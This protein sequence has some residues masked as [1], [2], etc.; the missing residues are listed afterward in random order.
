MA[1]F[2]GYQ[3]R[4]SR[5]VGTDEE[6]RLEIAR[7]SA[8]RADRNLLRR[9][10]HAIPQA[11]GRSTYSNLTANTRAEASSLRQ[12]ASQAGVDKGLRNASAKKAFE[13][14]GIRR[15][16]A[17]GRDYVTRAGGDTAKHGQ[18]AGQTSSALAGPEKVVET[19][20][21]AAGAA[22]ILTGG[23]AAPVVGISEGV[24]QGLVAGRT[25][26]NGTES[27]LHGH[28]ARTA[29]RAQ[30]QAAHSDEQAFFSKSAELHD[31][32][33]ELAA[34]KGARE[35]LNFIAP[36]ASEVSDL[37]GTLA[38]PVVN[39]AERHLDRREKT[40]KERRGQAIT[41]RSS[42]LADVSAREANTFAV[43]TQRLYRGARQ[44]TLLGS[45]QEHAA[46]VGRQAIDDKYGGHDGRRDF[47]ATQVQRVFRGHRAREENGLER[48][49]S[50]ATTI[51]ALGRGHIQRQEQRH[52]RAATD[53]AD[54]FAADSGA[55]TRGARRQERKNQQSL[56]TQITGHL[57]RAATATGHAERQSALHDAKAAGKQWLDKRSTVFGR[58]S[59]PFEGARHK[60][61]ND[62]VGHLSERQQKR[63]KK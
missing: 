22:T 52:K 36:F 48:K 11:M 28:A 39:A 21:V 7:G 61:I 31:A 33:S 2:F 63:S 53:L 54:K 30:S 27:L 49:R 13:V 1:G 45:L 10:Y 62:L 4:P 40:A 6:K 46:E 5:P 9:A 29:R 15:S 38:A 12:R 8:V 59:H 60:A 37:V 58:I 18:F 23:M 56:H 3:K 32:N 51:E 43:G 47:A 44:R 16:E 25:T 42:A 57:E 19:F 17:T 20:E 24:R 26:L 41:E 35:A 34:G 55:K 14:E 50:A